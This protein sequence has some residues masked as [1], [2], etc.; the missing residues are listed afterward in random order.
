MTAAF[1]DFVNRKQ[2]KKQEKQRPSLLGESPPTLSY[3]L[4]LNLKKTSF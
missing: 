4:T 2:S 1:Q 3:I